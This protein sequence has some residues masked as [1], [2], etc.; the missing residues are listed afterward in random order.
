MLASH[1]SS[2]RLENRTGASTAHSWGLSTPP[3]SARMVEKALGVE[4][5][6]ILYVGD[7]IY[8][9]AALAK[10]NFRRAGEGGS[11]KQVAWGPQSWCKWPG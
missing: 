9:D 10:I 5:D 2:P 7:H 4:G 1:A 3:P 8:T 6:D 11:S